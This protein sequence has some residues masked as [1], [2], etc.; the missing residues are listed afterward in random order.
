[1][2]EVLLNPYVSVFLYI[3]AV[4]R[5]SLMITNEDGFL[6]ITFALRLFG[7]EVVLPEKI[8]YFEA[9]KINVFSPNQAIQ[10]K[11]ANHYGK[12]ISCI[13]CTSTWVAIFA[14]ISMYFNNFYL[15]C[16][17]YIMGLNGLAIL[18][19]KRGFGK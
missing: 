4:W 3:V 5:I 18:I 11:V 6:G 10:L 19:H 7:M 12:L 1:M 2:F 8:G 15:N 9:W 17:F 13:M 16:F 14:L